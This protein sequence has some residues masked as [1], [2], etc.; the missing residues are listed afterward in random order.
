MSRTPEPLVSVII[1]CYN[2]GDFIADALESVLDQQHVAFEVLVVDDGSPDGDTIRATVARHTAAPIQLLREPHRGL[3]ATRNAGIDAA[4]GSL[5]AFLDADDAWA[6]GFLAA[7][8]EL[9]RSS[10]ADLVYCDATFFGSP[11]HEGGSV[12][13]SNPS[14]PDVSMEAVLAG[15]CVPVMSTILARADAVRRVGAFDATLAY[16]EDF[17]LWVRMLGDGCTFAWSPEARARRRIHDANLSRD[18][19]R[20]A[21]AQI[22]VIQR[23]FDRVAPAHPLL[24]EIRARLR[25]L[26]AEIRLARATAA[27]QAGDASGGRRALWEVVRA[28]GGPKHAAAAL[29]LTVAPTLAL[30]LLQKRLE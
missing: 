2:A 22:D 4:R 23:Y 18:T 10:G 29:A 12:M 19:A 28:G 26:E 25:R 13:G 20:M 21:R 14:A 1:P 3:A 30:P 11:E 6:S 16:C 27:I 5:L 8:L 7:Q 24:P 17:D 9:L 15:S